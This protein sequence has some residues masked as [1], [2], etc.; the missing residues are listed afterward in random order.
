[1]VCLYK[2]VVA[3]NCLFLSDLLLFVSKLL[4]YCFSLVLWRC[5]HYVVVVK[6]CHHKCTDLL[7]FTSRAR[8]LLQRTEPAAVSEFHLPTSEGTYYV[9]TSCRAPQGLMVGSFDVPVSILW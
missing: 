2:I 9:V 4:L 6:S 7:L 3:P 5:C 1:V 8:Q